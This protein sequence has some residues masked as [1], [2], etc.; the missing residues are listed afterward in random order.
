MIY[1]YPRLSKT[2]LWFTRIGGDGLGNLLFNWARCLVT[3]RDRGW[4]VVWP[5]W[6]SHKPKNKRVNP[7][8]H[9]LYDDLFLPT[10]EYV[11]GWR[12][13]LVLASRRW[14]GEAEALAAP[15]SR[16]CVVQFRGMA[17]KFEPFLGE[18]DWVREQLLAITRPEHLA[19]YRAERPA[20]VTI[21]VRRGD[22]EWQPDQETRVRKDNSA[23]P[24]EWYV[25]ALGA[26]RE[27]LGRP[28]EAW[29]FSDGTAAE[30]EPL[31]R[32]P[33][34]EAELF[35]RGHRW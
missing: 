33:G 29:V 10:A 22:F 15:P 2:D 7:Y 3:A 16:S 35:I 21:H 9:R 28:V 18:V 1:A 34:V 30:L 31:L 6:K 25:D 26:V 23:L 32:E 11:H 17:G 14:M 19:G 8:D 13:P 27:R 20:P 12:K 5:T 4:R 24:I